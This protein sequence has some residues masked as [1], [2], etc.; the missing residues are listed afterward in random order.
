M[1]DYEDE[2]YFYNQFLWD[3]NPFLCEDGEFV[4]TEGDNGK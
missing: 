3:F 4:I 2:D 1:W